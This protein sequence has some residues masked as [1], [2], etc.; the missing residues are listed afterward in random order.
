MKKI[1]I[2]LI[3]MNMIALIA[4]IIGSVFAIIDNDNTQILICVGLVVMCGTHLYGCINVCQIKNMHTQF[5]HL[6]E[7]QYRIANKLE[8]I[9][10]KKLEIK[11]SGKATKKS[12]KE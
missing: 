3:I 7:S 9:D 10:F 6:L 11:N 8:D 2:F 1:S 5:N 12:S 4:V